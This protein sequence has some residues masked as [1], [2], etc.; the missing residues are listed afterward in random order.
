MGDV[1]VNLSIVVPVY[2]S[3]GILAKL[4]EEINK[5]MSCLNMT[6]EIILVNDYST[7]NTMKIIDEYAKNDFRVKGIHLNK[8]IG[9]FKATLLGMKISRGEFIINMDDDMEHPPSEIIKLI[10]AIKLSNDRKIVFGLSPDKYKVKGSWGFP[11]IRNYL[12]N[13]LWG[14]YPTD[15][16][17]IL[18]RDVVFMDEKFLPKI[19]L[20]EAF[21]KHNVDRKNVFYIEV[22]HHPRL[23]GVSN[24]NLFKKIKLFCKMSPYFWFK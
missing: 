8:N 19:T 2:N 24:Y 12:I 17:R 1:Y 11:Q 14:K 3:E 13:F 7:D 20:L 16:F 18:R 5:V 23:K 9:Q 21:L 6:Y 10:D 4:I 22:D 15:S